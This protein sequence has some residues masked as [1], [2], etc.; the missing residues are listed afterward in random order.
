MYYIGGSRLECGVQGLGFGVYGLGFTIWCLGFRIK[1]V[2][3][4]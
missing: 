4:L 1:R 2:V 3:G